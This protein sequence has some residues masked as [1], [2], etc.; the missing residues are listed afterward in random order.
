MRA[1]GRSVI[2]NENSMLIHQETESAL[3][4][5]MHSDRVCVGVRACV[6][7]GWECFDPCLS[8]NTF[9]DPRRHDVGSSNS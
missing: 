8:V 2:P 1:D 9:W 3:T 6:F 4:E 5:A 7:L